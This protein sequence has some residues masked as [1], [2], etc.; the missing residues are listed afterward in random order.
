MDDSE[1]LVMLIKKGHSQYV[2]DV[3]SSRAYG[4]HGKLLSCEPYEITDRVKEI[5]LPKDQSEDIIATCLLATLGDIDEHGEDSEYYD[6]RK[7]IEKQWKVLSIKKPKHG[8]YTYSYLARLVRYINMGAL[9]FLMEARDSLRKTKARALLDEIFTI[10]ISGAYGKI[11]ELIKGI[12]DFRYLTPLC[13]E[14]I[15]SLCAEEIHWSAANEEEMERA[16]Q[17]VEAFEYYI[18]HRPFPPCFGTS[19]VT[20]AAWLVSRKPRKFKS[21]AQRI[22]SDLLPHTIPSVDLYT[23]ISAL[24]ATQK[25]RDELIKALKKAGE[26]GAV[27]YEFSWAGYS[28]WDKDMEVQAL[29]PK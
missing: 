8:P 4:W 11:V 17:F 24:Y 18:Q 28:P 12:E 14:A 16:E 10:Y 7:E 1:E 5:G 9:D 15:A 23:R 3:A 22:V 20:A 2:V 21:L 25:Q 29:L 26:Y 27:Y 13:D 19:V 6:D